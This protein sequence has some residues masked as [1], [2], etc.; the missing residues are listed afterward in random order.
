M[1]HSANTM[2][3]PE[4]QLAVALCRM[5]LDA[6]Q[7]DR[8]RELIASGLDFPALIEQAR[9]WQVEPVVFGNLRWHF[10]EIIPSGV[11]AE[12]TELERAQRAYAMS[13]TLQL[14]DLTRRLKEAGIPTIVL[15]GPTIGI[16]AYG[17]CSR[18]AFADI[19]L[20]VPKNYLTAAHDLLIARG[21]TPKFG[22]EMIAAIVAGQHALEFSGPGPAVE[23]HWSL[24]SRHLR[25]DLEP[26]ELWRDARTLECVGSEISALSPPHLFLYLC[27][28]GAKHE[29]NIFRWVCDVAQ[30]ARRLTA[31][32][33]EHV[34]ALAKRTNSRRIV[35]LALRLARET[36]GEEESPF[37]PTAFGTPE[38]T[39]SLIAV[40]KA[41][42][43]GALEQPTL[44]PARIARLHPYAA[45]LAFWIRSRERRSDQLACAA[46]FIFEPAPGDFRGGAFRFLVRPAR[47]AANA[48]M[49]AF[50][51]VHAS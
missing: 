21:Y 26:D 48:V 18:R 37:P 31:L 30:L 44:L 22:P 15:K 19:D 9:R 5:P 14:V 17:D 12:I 4:Q 29:W 34:M 38:E 51:T 50:D 7:V 13:H 2:I 3:R 36:F 16:T 28:H 40:A 1:Q 25:F 41:S 23:V 32:D 47:L 33:A 27:A 46:R 11:L 6:Q 24:L 42:F 8:A 39:D 49:R 35:A 43:E 10:A 20:L 45:P